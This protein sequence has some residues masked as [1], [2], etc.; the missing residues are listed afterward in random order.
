MHFGNVFN[1]VVEME[2]NKNHDVKISMIFL[3][4]NNSEVA[5]FTPFILDVVDALAV[6]IN[7]MYIVYLCI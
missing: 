6:L 5:L 3:L 2:N 1:S 4:F 7:P